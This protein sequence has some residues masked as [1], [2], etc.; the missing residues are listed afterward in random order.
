MSGFFED[1]DNDFEQVGSEKNQ[2]NTG[3]NSDSD[4]DERELTIEEQIV[5]AIK[6]DEWY[7]FTD[8]ARMSFDEKELA[9]EEVIENMICYILKGTSRFAGCY[10][11]NYRDHLNELRYRG[12]VTQ[13][14]MEKAIA[15][16]EQIKDSSINLDQKIKIIHEYVGDTVDHI[17][18]Q[19]LR[20][21]NPTR[22]DRY[23]PELV[24]RTTKLCNT[25]CLDQIEAPVG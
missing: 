11:K 22:E 19:V 12:L 14:K 25:H 3:N 1:E 20:A 21:W 5:E 15:T 24:G 7:E 9:L 2:D 8:C 18:D 13:E 17:R 10:F 4:K 23:D 6:F 16:I